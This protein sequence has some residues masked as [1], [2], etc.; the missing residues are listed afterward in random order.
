MLNKKVES[1]NFGVLHRIAYC[2]S[3][4]WNEGLREKARTRAISHTKKNWSQ[5]SSRNRDNQNL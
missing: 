1:K 5:N 3:C 2:E 4:D